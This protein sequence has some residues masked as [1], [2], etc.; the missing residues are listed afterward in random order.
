MKKGFLKIGIIS[1][2][3]FGFSKF[4]FAGRPL[5]TDDAYTVEK[6]KFELEIGYDIIENDDRTKNQE[7]GFSLKAGLTSWMD[8]GISTSFIYKENDEK[9]NEWQNMEIGAK[10]LILKNNEK[11]PKIAFTISGVPNPDEGDKRYSINSILSKE[12]GKT[13]FHLNLGTYSLKTSE[14]NENFLTYCCAL[15]Y[16]LNEKMNLC[17][18]IVG[19][20]NEENPL[21]ILLGANFPLN[22][23]LTIDFG[24]SFG[25]NDDS[26]NWRVTTGLTLNW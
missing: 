7:I 10:F 19:E 21:E 12:F 15:E 18:E 4:L 3:F 6:G 13:T 23:N 25:L 17:G 1:I 22:E 24:F 2:L 20:N 16:S 14:K 8:L 9:L 5:T 11:L 26:S